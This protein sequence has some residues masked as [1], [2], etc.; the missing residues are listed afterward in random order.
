MKWSFDCVFYYVSDIERSVRFYTEILGLKLTSR[1][2]VARFHV[3]GV[4]LELVPAEDDSKLGGA[5]NARVCFEVPE[6]ERSVSE[7]KAKGVSTGD[8]QTVANGRLARFEDPDGNELV[9]WQY[10]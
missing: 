1:D 6:I 3:D 9:L 5:G 7:L 2:S 4:L 10:L 8:V